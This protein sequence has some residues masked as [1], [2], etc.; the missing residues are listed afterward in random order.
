[1]VIKRHINFIVIDHRPIEFKPAPNRGVSKSLLVDPFRDFPMLLVL[2]RS[3]EGFL[4][5]TNLSYGILR[6]R[7]HRF[8]T[9]PK[10]NDYNH[11]APVLQK[12]ISMLR[13]VPTLV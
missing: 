9:L 4:I 5:V 13:G 11:G 2:W 7:A 8:W 10:K 1:M 6:Y 12:N 3:A